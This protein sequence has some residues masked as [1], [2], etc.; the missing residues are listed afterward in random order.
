MSRH[1]LIQILN[2]HAS[3]AEELSESASVHLKRS[4]TI[5]TLRHNRP[6]DNYHLSFFLPG[7]EVKTQYYGSPTRHSLPLLVTTTAASG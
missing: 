1:V 2:H 3:V 4:Q 5:D 7:A 6:A